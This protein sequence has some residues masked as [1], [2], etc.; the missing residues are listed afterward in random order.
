MENQHQSYQGGSFL[1][2]LP[3]YLF[4]DFGVSTSLLNHFSEDAFSLNQFHGTA[5]L[6]NLTSVHHDDLVV[7]GDGVESVGDRQDGGV[8]ESFANAFLDEAV[9]LH[10]HVRSGLIQDQEFVVSEKGSRQ[11]KQLLLPH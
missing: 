5:C 9:G 6:Y 7:V 3:C 8:G 1:S 2:R 4:D 10:I 11:A